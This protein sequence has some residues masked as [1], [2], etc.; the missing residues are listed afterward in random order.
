MHPLFY[1]IIFSYLIIIG[2]HNESKLSISNI[3]LAP[4]IL[5]LHIGKILHAYY[6][7]LNKP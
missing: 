3:I 1:Y 5:P 2:I 4:I 6:R 7:S